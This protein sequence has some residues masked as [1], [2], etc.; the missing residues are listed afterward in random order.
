MLYS[1]KGVLENVQSKQE[2]RNLSF[3]SLRSWFYSRELLE[4]YSMKL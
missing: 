4:N 1:M 3:E 2:I